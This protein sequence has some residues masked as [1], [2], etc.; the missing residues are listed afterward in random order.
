MPGVRCPLKN[1]SYVTPD[2]VAHPE[3]II[4]ILQLHGKE[5]DQSTSE[6]LDS[7]A[8]GSDDVAPSKSSDPQPHGKECNQPADATKKAECRTSSAS[9]ALD[10]DASGDVTPSKS[11]ATGA[12]HCMEATMTESVSSPPLS[13]DVQR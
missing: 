6:A 12:R 8:S 5:H 3:L 1:C 4:A 9:E 10:S 2:D 13:D 11:C 7:D